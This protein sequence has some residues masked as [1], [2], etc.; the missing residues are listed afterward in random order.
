MAMAVIDG[1]AA[2]VRRDQERFV[3]IAVEQRRERM[4]LVMV[5]ENNLGIV[6][7]AAGAP[8][9]V[10]LEDIVNVPGVISQKLLGI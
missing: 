6:A 10:D 7:K 3:P 9:F 1:I 4:R 8:E 2:C 5:V